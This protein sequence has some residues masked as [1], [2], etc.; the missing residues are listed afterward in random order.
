MLQ[1]ASVTVP[2]RLLNRREGSELGPSPR[3]PMTA[4]SST[5]RHS[6]DRDVSTRGCTTGAIPDGRGHIRMAHATLQSGAR[7]AGAHLLQ[8]LCGSCVAV[9]DVVGSKIS[10]WGAAIVVGR[11]PSAA[12]VW[13]IVLGVRHIKVADLLVCNAPVHSAQ[14]LGVLAAI[15]AEGCTE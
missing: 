5:C 1:S 2:R 10:G 8:G 3:Q 9:H 6:C 11:K 15:L 14:E 4:V 12:A 13:R 7:A